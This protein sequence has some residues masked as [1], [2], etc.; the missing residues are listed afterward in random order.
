[1]SE[2]GVSHIECIL[3][4]CDGVLVDSEIIANR[5]FSIELRKFGIILSEEELIKRFVGKSAATEFAALEESH[6]VRF[7]QEAIEGIE[8]AILK[9]LAEEVKAIDG[10]ESILKNLQECGNPAYAVASSG[11]FKK[12]HQSLTTSGL[13]SYFNSSNIFSSQL[14][15]HGKPAPDLFLFAAEKMGFSPQKCLVVEDSIAGI[16]AAKSAGMAV[17]GFTGGLHAKYPWYRERLKETGVKI[18][19]HFG[20]LMTQYKIR[21]R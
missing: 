21:K 19:D 10:I 18:F 5:H 15:K 3:F 8:G 16:Q 14:V 20:D 17:I 4:D 11:T 12:I 6:K 1:M 13:S 2:V 9:G 7:S